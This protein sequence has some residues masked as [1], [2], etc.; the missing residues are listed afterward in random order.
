M[1]AIVI[2]PVKREVKGIEIEL[3]GVHLMY[4]DA[5]LVQTMIGLPHIMYS[6]GR[7]IDTKQNPFW[8]KGLNKVIYGK[9]L[10]LGRNK[11]QWPVATMLSVREV[12][13]LVKFPS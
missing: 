10:L 5:I 8:F 13:C 3:L 4:K 11:G 6:D 9:G 1:K 7:G 2:D 12:E